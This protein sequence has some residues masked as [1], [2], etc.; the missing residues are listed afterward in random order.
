MASRRASLYEDKHYKL[1][2]PWVLNELRKIRN[3][4]NTIFFYSL[5]WVKALQKW[6]LP[7]KLVG[8]IINLW[9]RIEEFVVKK[10]IANFPKTCKEANKFVKDSLIPSKYYHHRELSFVKKLDLV[11]MTEQQVK[12]IC[13][14]TGNFRSINSVLNFRNK[15]LREISECVY[16]SDSDD[17]EKTMLF[18][19]SN[20]VPCGQ[21]TD[22]NVSFKHVSPCVTDAVTPVP[23]IEEEHVSRFDMEAAEA[24]LSL[25]GHC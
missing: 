11:S 7:Q 9:L 3:C 16:V 20:V 23:Q 15:Q 8:Q 17:D 19:T 12:F 22:M 13:L 25:A 5:D 4:E 6:R 21:N 10:A 18:S 1:C 24:L 2:P 14:A